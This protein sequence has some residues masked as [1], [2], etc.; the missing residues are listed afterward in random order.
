MGHLTFQHT[1]V[2]QW[3]AQ[4]SE[5]I[6]QLDWEIIAL[7]QVKTTAES[8]LEEKLLFGQL[9]SRCEEVKVSIN[10]GVLEQDPVLIELKKEVQLT[11]KTTE[12]FQKQIC[13]LLDKLSSL[14]EIHA[15]LLVDYLDKGEAIKI[16]TKCLIHDINSP[17]SQFPVFEDKP[18]YISCD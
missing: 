17:S 16:N 3:Q 9:M 14:K 11:N 8:F 2:T 10:T 6:R 1:E 13:I 5:T 12:L 18:R 7:E 15:K 4:I